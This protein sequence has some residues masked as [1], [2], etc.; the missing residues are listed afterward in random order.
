M[1]EVIL[2]KLA[3][4]KSCLAEYGRLPKPGNIKESSNPNPPNTGHIKVFNEPG[5]VHDAI[6]YRPYI[7]PC[8]PRLDRLPSVRI[9][10]QTVHARSLESAAGLGSRLRARSSHGSTGWSCP[11]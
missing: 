3:L 10:Q 7:A 4:T 8:V 1:T 5:A 2:P 9:K 6:P 11:A